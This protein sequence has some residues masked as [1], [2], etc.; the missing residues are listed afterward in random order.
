MNKPKGMSR[1][2]ARN[3]KSIVRET[4][5]NPQATVEFTEYGAAGHQG[6]STEEGYFSEV[7]EVSLTEKPGVYSVVVDRRERDCDGRH[8]SHDESLVGFRGKRPRFYMSRNWAKNR[9]TGK[10]EVKS[11]WKVLSRVDSRQRDFS[12]EAAGY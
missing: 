1:Q 11:Q 6:Y 12:A 2:D 8:S 3:L 9:P 10:F 5:G 7:A 4:L